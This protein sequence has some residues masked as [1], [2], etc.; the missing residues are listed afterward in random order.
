MKNLLVSDIMTRNPNTVQ[1]G[2]N[3]L[4]CAKIMV[5]KTAGSLLI[6]DKNK[7]YGIITTHDI[8]WALIKKTK[9][10]LSAIKAIDISPKKIAVVKPNATVEEA[11]R[12]MK[13]LKFERLPVVH[14]KELVGIITVKDILSFHP[15]IYPELDEFAQI[16]D[17]EEKLSRIRKKGAPELSEEGICEECGIR[18]VLYRFNGMLVCESCMNST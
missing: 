8:L 1:P 18:N 5:R 10:D 3:L 6:T 15:E 13:T 11:L 12:K 17:E 14:E 9:E 2:T 7:L 4:E 16:K